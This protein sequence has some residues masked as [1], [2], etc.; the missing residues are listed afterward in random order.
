M[1]RSLVGSE[2]CIR[3]SINAEYGGSREGMCT[4]HW[5][6][7]CLALDEAPCFTLQGHKGRVFD[8]S[9]GELVL[10]CVGAVPTPT[11]AVATAG[12]DGR[13]RVWDLATHKLIKTLKGHKSEAMRVAWH[14]LPDGTST[15]MLASGGT[16]GEAFIWDVSMGGQPILQLGHSKESQIYVCDWCPS[17]SPLADKLL[18]GADEVL[19]AWDVNTA[20][21]VAKHSFAVHKDADAVI[22]GET[23][24]ADRLPVSY[25]HLTLP[26]KRIV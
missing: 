12:E 22:G 11:K 17:W 8:A 5:E 23:H 13:V 2:M 10:P 3:D 24:N 21:Q 9:F 7:L 16:E 19:H 20:K 26:T 6:E 14:A 1:L 15:A 18:T 25:T 4:A